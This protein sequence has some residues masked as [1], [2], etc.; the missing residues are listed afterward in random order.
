MF[1][2]KPEKFICANFLTPLHFL[3]PRNAI[4][5]SCLGWTGQWGLPAQQEVRRRPPGA[6]GL[7][8]RLRRT[9]RP[10]VARHAARVD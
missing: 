3:T 7:P 6:R 1:W 2:E 9:G 10:Q 5:C 8:Y 4:L